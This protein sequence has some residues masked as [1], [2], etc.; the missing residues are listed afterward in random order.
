M[1]TVFVLLSKLNGKAIR[2]QRIL[3]VF[4]KVQ[5][6]S[7]KVILEKIAMTNCLTKF[8]V[9]LTAKTLKDISWINHFGTRILQFCSDVHN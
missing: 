4:Q 8:S 5:R 3:T 6:M 2:K 9:T 1:K 7:R